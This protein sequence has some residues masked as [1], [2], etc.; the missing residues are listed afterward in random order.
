[1]TDKT[2]D[3]NSWKMF[4]GFQCFIMAFSMPL[5]YVLVKEMAPPGKPPA[6]AYTLLSISLFLMTGCGLCLIHRLI[7]KRNDFMGAYYMMATP[8][9]ITATKPPLPLRQLFGIRATLFLVMALIIVIIDLFA[10][11][12]DRRKSLKNKPKIAHD[13]LMDDTF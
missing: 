7:R 2:R 4:I 6:V 5:L 3:P 13:P 1:M 12:N 8:A 10:L 9:M 11:W